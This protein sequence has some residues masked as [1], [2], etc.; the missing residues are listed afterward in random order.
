MQDAVILFFVTVA[1]LG[2]A[3]PS[4]GAAEA[5]A[6]PDANDVAAAPDA[7]EPASASAALESA[8]PSGGQSEIIK[9]IE[10]EGN[11]KFKDHVLRERLGFALGEDLDP[12]LAEGGRLTIT[13]V[14]R[15]IGYAFVEVALDRALL[16]D[17][18]LLY[19]IEEG[20]R[21][22]IDSIEFVGNE[23]I[24][25]GTL[26]AVIKTAEKKWW[27]WP[28]YYTEDAVEEDLD[29]LREFYYDQGYLDYSIEAE[30]EMMADEGRVRLVFVIDE[31][32]VYRVGD[33]VI[34]GN[35]YFTDAELQAR[36][37]SGEGRVYRRPTA[38]REPW[39]H[40]RWRT[41]II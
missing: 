35:T 23:A 29:R 12:F 2:V 30:T 21:V 14:Y 16:D 7:N 10:F 27:L 24:G 17:G 31:G 4:A 6:A 1:W 41:S 5:V 8:A 34:T 40:C 28:Y 3:A 18:H 20:P 26:K 32:P 19:Y 15:K 39:P 38:R 37:E 11:R 9:S 33:I 22:Q 13:E 25:T 36:M